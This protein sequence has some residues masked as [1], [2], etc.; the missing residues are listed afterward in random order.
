MDSSS[1]KRISR[2]I[3]EHNGITNQLDVT[4]ISKTLY[5]ITSDNTSF[6]NSHGTV[7]LIDFILGYKTLFNKLRKVEIIQVLLGDHNIIKLEIN[8]EKQWRSP[9]PPSDKSDTTR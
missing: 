4:D 6:E 5:H 3:V 7:I 1:R 2:A 9:K 8:T